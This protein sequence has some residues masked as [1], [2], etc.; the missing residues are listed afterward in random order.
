M[1]RGRH[2]QVL[3]WAHIINRVVQ[4][5]LDEIKDSISRARSAVKYVKSSPRRK[6]EFLQYADQERIPRS[7]MLVLDV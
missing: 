4:D 6:M 5:G 1:L 3:C 7:R 2:L